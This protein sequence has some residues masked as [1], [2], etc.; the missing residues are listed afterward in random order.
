MHKETLGTNGEA[1]L[2]LADCLEILPT[3]DG[4]DAVVTDPPYNYGKAYGTHND[5]MDPA[6]FWSWLELRMS[7]LPINDGGVIYFTCSTQM[8]GRVQSWPWFR[9]RQW[10]IWHRPNLVNVHARADWKQTWEPIYYGGVG[11]FRAVSGVFPDSA[12]LT[13]PTPQTNFTEGRDHVAQRP[14]GL[15][16]TIIQR[17]QAT[18]ILDPFMGS[19]TTGVAAANLGR[20]FIGIEIEPK[21][22]EIAKRRI[23][24][25]YR[26]P[27]LFDE[28]KQEPEQLEVEW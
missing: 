25:A 20:R 2:Y 11:T 21:Y 13:Y 14:V 4:V 22:F 28:P 1:T 10:L 9:F 17:I 15:L 7:Q 12:V 23:E 8:M 27:S 5:N 24:E 18:T 26:Q 16:K 3:L 6:E 19:G